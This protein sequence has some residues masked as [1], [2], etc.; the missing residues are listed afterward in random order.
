MEKQIREHS[1]VHVLRIGKK[2]AP[3]ERMGIAKMDP[4]LPKGD[5]AR[6][7]REHPHVRATKRKRSM[8]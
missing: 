3:H 5:W 6:V 2:V 4:V 7:H 8:K 1:Q